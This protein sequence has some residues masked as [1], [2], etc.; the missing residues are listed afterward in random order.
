LLSLV[1]TME[2]PEQRLGVLKA[3][4]LVCYRDPDFLYRALDAY[5]DG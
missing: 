2:G 3:D 1:L 5:F 4:A